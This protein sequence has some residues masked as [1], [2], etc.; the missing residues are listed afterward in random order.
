MTI[1]SAPVDHIILPIQEI[2]GVGKISPLVVILC[3][4][5]SHG[6]EQL[7]VRQTQVVSS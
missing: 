2:E 6:N 1:S 5:K 4:L 3:L 7:M